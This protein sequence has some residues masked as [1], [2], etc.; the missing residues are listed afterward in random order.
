[1][2]KQSRIKTT[3]EP[4]SNRYVKAITVSPPSHD[5]TDS[6]IAVLRVVTT[7]A[8]VGRISLR[9][10]PRDILHEEKATAE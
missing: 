5:K 7:T 1:M 6:S 2:S 8:T 10:T 4:D 3:Q 9:Y